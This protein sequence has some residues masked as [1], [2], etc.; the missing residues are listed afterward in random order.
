MGMYGL[1]YSLYHAL[2]RATER[3]R[4]GEGERAEAAV[5]HGVFGMER[6]GDGNDNNYTLVF[7][8]LPLPLLPAIP[9]LVF[10]LII[11]SY[12]HSDCFCFIN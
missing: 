9:D 11:I 4:E 12:E 1:T 6:G 2:E 8:P 7:V 10:T 5:C 3:E